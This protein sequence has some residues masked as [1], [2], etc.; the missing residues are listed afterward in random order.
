MIGSAKVEMA[1]LDKALRK[2]ASESNMSLKQLTVR[3]ARNAVERAVEITPPSTEKVQG[4][5][6]RDRAGAK[7]AADIRRLFASASYAFSTI[8]DKKKAKL[9]WK[10]LKGKNQDFAKAQQILRENTYNTK[11]TTAEVS[12]Q[13]DT[14]LHR[15]F[16]SHGVVGNSR[17]VQQVIY[18]RKS[19]S[20]PIDQYI[21]TKQAMV[22]FWASG[23]NAAVQKL[24]ARKIPKWITKHTG[25]RGT[26][27]VP[28]KPTD[29]FFITIKNK[30]GFGTLARVI[31]YALSGARKGMI[32]EAEKA[33]A[34]ALEKAGLKK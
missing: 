26:C 17:R 28:E 7:I 27:D 5:E 13:M 22:G 1:N 9:F 20:G 10:F 19:K 12:D 34:K 4:L 25:V 24:K 14:T 21:K 16:R 29:K 15:K 31:P 8:K 11:V 3:A 23:W 2:L 33:K 6:A 32:A 30:T 18:S